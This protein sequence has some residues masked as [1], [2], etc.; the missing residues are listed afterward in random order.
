[1]SSNP[2]F[3]QRVTYFLQWSSGNFGFKLTSMADGRTGYP[4]SKSPMAIAA[5]GFKLTTCDTGSFG[6]M[7]KCISKNLFIGSFDLANA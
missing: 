7:V 1:M 2:N 4:T 5:K 3:N 6:A